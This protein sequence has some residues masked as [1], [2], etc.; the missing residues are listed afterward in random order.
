MTL[1]YAATGSSVHMRF[2]P[3]VVVALQVAMG[4]CLC[5]SATSDVADRVIHHVNELA[6]RCGAMKS[7]FLVSGPAVVPWNPTNTEWPAVPDAETIVE[8]CHKYIWNHIDGRT[9]LDRMS[10]AD[11]EQDNL[12]E[13]SW[14]WNGSKWYMEA[15]ETET[16]P[17]QLR[18]DAFSRVDVIPF[19]DVW[20]GCV[21]YRC[22]VMANGLA[23]TLTSSNVISESLTAERV[24]VR[25]RVPAL[26][27][28]ADIV[29][30]CDVNTEG[31]YALRRITVETFDPAT[32]ELIS[33]NEFTIDEWGDFGG[34]LIP[35]R[36]H[37]WGGRPGLAPRIERGL[38]PV[39]NY[40]EFVRVSAEQLDRE[41]GRS[42]VFEPKS[43]THGTWVRDSTLRISYTIG[44]ASIIVDGRRIQLSKPIEAMITD[45]L[46]E[47]LQTSRD[48]GIE[49]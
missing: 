6:E 19:L 14:M 10:K 28:R 48:R 9:R 5:E 29:V 2:D 43:P 35:I 4:A 18:V 7:E 34:L 22:G 15:P 40:T 42:Q 49:R 13:I 16:T 46:P 26:R 31:D 25:F 33:R 45:N 17:R 1:D 21:D 20:N 38:K 41:S 30:T 23:A 12:P 32:D 24:S 47:I 39:A 44:G 37:L 8:R 27:S 36:A 3:S 11:A